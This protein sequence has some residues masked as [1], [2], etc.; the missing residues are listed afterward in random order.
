M[1]L[2]SIRWAAKAAAVGDFTVL[3]ALPRRERRAVGPVCFLDHMGPHTAIGSSDGGVGPHPHI[4]LSTVTYLFEGDILHRDS[5]GTEQRIHP[6]DVNWMTAGR[7]IAHSE[8]TPEE[9]LGK[10]STMHGL[11]MWVALPPER[12]DGDPSFQHV[13]KADLPKEVTPTYDL[14]VV[15]GEWNGKVS[16]VKVASP[17][18]Y[19]V[20]EL[21]PGA[22]L[23]VPTQYSE[24]A[25]YV[26]EGDVSIDGDSFVHADFAILEP[27][28]EG[29][30]NAN[31]KARV[32]LFG[33]EPLGSERFMWWNFVSSRKSLIEQA[34]LDWKN[35]NWPLIPG[36]SEDRIPEP[37]EEP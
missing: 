3:R 10:P 37:G 24:R 4:G 22:S 27:G 1:P 13:A 28:V 8:R 17:T 11:Q 32:A 21:E 6:G 9:L 7:G 20:A 29:C 2:V 19:V 31:T 34:K 18:F 14:C 25:V 23:E 26:V 5:L 12:E 33:G 36:D 15:L 16:P 35:R 30:I